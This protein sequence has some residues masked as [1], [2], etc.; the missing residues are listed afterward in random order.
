MSTKNMEYNDYLAGFLFPEHPENQERE[1]HLLSLLKA[2]SQAR[3]MEK[4][5]SKNATRT[6]GDNSSHEHG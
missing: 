2:C 4:S 3:N 5:F 6:L 1:A